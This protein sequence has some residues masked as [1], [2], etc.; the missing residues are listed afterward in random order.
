[1][2]VTDSAPNHTYGLTLL[3]VIMRMELREYRMHISGTCINM[4]FRS[5]SPSPSKPGDC[6]Y[7]ASTVWVDYECD[8]FLHTFI[9]K[10]RMP[11]LY[12]AKIHDETYA[13]PAFVH[14]SWEQYIWCA[15]L[16][17]WDRTQVFSPALDSWRTFVFDKVTIVARRPT[18]N[19]HTLH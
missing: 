13:L 3:L 8:I 1:M 10:M 2:H 6:P 11:D 16:P 12:I 5:M 14:D 15:A 9:S 18:R 17:T 19:K 7:M 4:R